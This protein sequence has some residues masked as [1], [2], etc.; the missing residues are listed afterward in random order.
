MEINNTQHIPMK[1]KNHLMLLVMWDAPVM[2][3]PV[4]IG[5]LSLGAVAAAVVAERTGRHVRNLC[6]RFE[7]R[8]AG[9]GAQSEGKWAAH[10]RGTCLQWKAPLWSWT[11]VGRAVK[12]FTWSEHTVNYRHLSTGATSVLRSLLSCP[13][14][15]PPSHPFF[16]FGGNGSF[17]PAKTLPSPP[18]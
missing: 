6:L 1:R 8:A 17:L 13:S 2:R 16:F 3:A 18:H 7:R 12:P 10:C 5:E 11:G 15:F 14:A 4:C 9:S